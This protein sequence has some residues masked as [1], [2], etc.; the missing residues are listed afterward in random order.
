MIVRMFCVKV[1]LGDI[2]HHQDIQKYW[3]TMIKSHES[4]FLCRMILCLFISVIGADFAESFT[5]IAESPLSPERKSALWWLTQAAQE[6]EAIKPSARYNEAALQK[7]GLTKAD[8]QAL[9][10]EPWNDREEA[11]RDLYLMQVRAGD[12][13]GALRSVGESKDGG[14]MQIYRV[15]ATTCFKTGDKPGYRS[16]MDK[17]KA[18]TSR[19]DLNRDILEVYLDCQDP[20]GARMYAD[21][22]TTPWARQDAYRKIACYWVCN[23]ETAKANAF[24]DAQFD[25]SGK[26]R[27]LVDVVEACALQGKFSIAEEFLERITKEKLSEE[28]QFLVKINATYQQRARGAIG[29]AYADTGNISEAQVIAE[30]MVE[31]QSR[32]RVREAIALAYVKAGDIEAAQA[33][34][35]DM[36]GDHQ[37]SVYDAIVSEQVAEGQ[38]EAAQATIEAWVRMIDEFPYATYP[39]FYLDGPN[40]S[41]M[42]RYA[43]RRYLTLAQTAAEQGDMSAYHHFLE[44]A[45]AG[46]EMEADKKSISWDEI[47][48]T[49]YKVG[50]LVGMLT[51]AETNEEESTRSLAL[52]LVTRKLS[53]DG[54]ITTAMARA[55]QI[56]AS[57]VK[58][59]AYAA[60][61]CA[62]VR[63]DRVTEGQAFLDTLTNE[64]HRAEA[65]RC[66]A[67]D[68]VHMDRQEVLFDWLKPVDSPLVRFKVPQTRGYRLEHEVSAT[69][70]NWRHSR[71][72]GSLCPF[73]CNT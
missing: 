9:G 28:E 21:I 63:L 67:I 54:D 58:S 64:R 66:A 50:D 18:L 8:L 10:V 4:Q 25:G 59:A 56:P 23:G 20:N 29:E 68:L 36:P 69:R 16:Y 40:I 71:H 43:K 12:I 2:G 24:L 35:K 55:K 5:P 65:Y 51:I 22:L 14:R 53:R 1:P 47:L 17:A 61:A 62:M 7:H 45:K 60:V 73:S 31:S 57:R 52:S 3:M 30:N 26:R 13:D 48:L 6:A 38:L 72:I 11:F 46:A 39:Y 15:A 32:S 33:M 41:L 37:I 27:V 70:R 34:L 19:I 44:Q 49:Q 42:R